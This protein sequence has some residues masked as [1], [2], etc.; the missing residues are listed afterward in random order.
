MSEDER[1]E[2]VALAGALQIKVDDVF[3]ENAELRAEA[4]SLRVT[5]GLLTEETAALRKSLE[6]AVRQ[7]DTALRRADEA[8]EAMRK[9]A[10]TANAALR[11]IHPPKQRLTGAPAAVI[12]HPTIHSVQIP[13]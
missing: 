7:R 10:A 1:Q 2:A 9:I 3:A 11:P 4:E 12:P 6:Q 5:A 13:H 8:E